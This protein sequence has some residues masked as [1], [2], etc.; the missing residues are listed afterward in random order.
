MTDNPWIYTVK[1]FLAEENQFILVHH[2]INP[3]S[4]FPKKALRNITRFFDSFG[5]GFQNK[6]SG[7]PKVL[8]SVKQQ[9]S[10]E[11][12]PS[13]CCDP[14]NSVENVLPWTQLISRTIYRGEIYPNIC[15]LLSTTADVTRTTIRTNLAYIKLAGG[16]SMQHGYGNDWMYNRLSRYFAIT[17]I[18]DPNPNV[19]PGQSLGRW[20]LDAPLIPSNP[21]N[22]KRNECI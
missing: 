8:I 13:N 7:D 10:H 18:N 1:Q 16:R 2:K 9:I 14:W 11:S 12:I 20:R 5:T 6:R 4:K 17:C 22:K 15:V 19:Q 3:N 21:W